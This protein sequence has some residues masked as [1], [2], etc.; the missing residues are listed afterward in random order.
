[1]T[2]DI[3]GD[4]NAWRDGSTSAKIPKAVANPI[5]HHSSDAVAAQMV[6]NEEPY[7]AAC[8]KRRQAQLRIREEFAA[9]IFR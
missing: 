5:D 3:P 6:L 8:A 1:M 9:H 4:A 2:G 7:A